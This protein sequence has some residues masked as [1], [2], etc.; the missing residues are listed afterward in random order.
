MHF[1]LL[2]AAPHCTL[3]C[4]NNTTSL[5]VTGYNLG[6]SRS[7][8]CPEAITA[9]W[10]LRLMDWREVL[11]PETQWCERQLSQ[12]MFQDNDGRKLRVSRWKRGIEWKE[13][14]KVSKSRL[15]DWSFVRA[16][17]ISMLETAVLYTINL[18]FLVAVRNCMRETDDWST[19]QNQSIKKS[20]GR[21]QC[22]S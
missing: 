19:L 10:T 8:S 12:L 3:C 22:N 14:M 11:P 1:L 21:L 5:C 6:T 15:L 7:W 16:S 13:G 2:D 18:T 17:F 20:S 9:L 4:A